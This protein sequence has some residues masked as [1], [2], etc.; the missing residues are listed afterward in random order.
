MFTTHPHQQILITPIGGS[1]TYL[2]CH[3]FSLR[4][5]LTQ[6]SKIFQS[7]QKKSHMQQLTHTPAENPSTNIHGY[8]QSIYDINTQRQE[9][10]KGVLIANT[11]KSKLSS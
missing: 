6:K 9:P 4:I 10:E 2:I 8:Q 1:K 11:V 3:S 7:L 5:K